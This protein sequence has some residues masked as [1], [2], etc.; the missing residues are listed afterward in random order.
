MAQQRF[1]SAVM[2]YWCSK[3]TIPYRS[4]T[5]GYAYCA[6][7]AFLTAGLR[8]PNQ[9]INHPTYDTALATMPSGIFLHQITQK[10]LFTTLRLF[11]IVLF[12]V[13]YTLSK[14]REET[15]TM[16]GLLALFSINTVVYTILD[17]PLT[18]VELIGTIFGLWSVIL[19][20]RA[21]ILELP[22]WDYQHHF[23][24]CYVL[25]SAIVCRH[26][27]TGLLFVD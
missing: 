6:C 15:Q 5:A 9:Y 13:I 21:S 18:L 8:I 20:A 17:Y 10:S 12:S 2:P 23:L 14:K 1:G 26:D 3:K 24:F 4:V 7:P 11:D 16:E 25:S 22:D 19:A 27:I